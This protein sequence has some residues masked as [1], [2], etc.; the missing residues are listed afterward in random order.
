LLN[1]DK[2]VFLISADTAP[3]SALAD[4]QQMPVEIVHVNPN[5]VWSSLSYNRDKPELALFNSVEME[6]MY[7]LYL[8]SK[9]NKCPRVL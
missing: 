4:V 8:Y 9:F 5:K 3:E 6:E 1:A 7:S 2:K